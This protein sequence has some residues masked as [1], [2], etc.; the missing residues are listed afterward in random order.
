MPEGKIIGII[1]LKLI[2]LIHCKMA[3]GHEKGW[4]LNLRIKRSHKNFKLSILTFKLIG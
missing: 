1:N 3:R 4:Q 2:Y